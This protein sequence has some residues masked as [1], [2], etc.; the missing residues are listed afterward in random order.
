M[1]KP[2]IFMIMPFEDGFFEVYEMI[3]SKFNDKFEF[4]NA[5]VEDYQQN[6]LADIIQPL[7]DADLVLADLTGFN[8]NVMYELGVA[9]TFGKKTII[10][11]QDELSGLPFD[12][13]TY[14]TK[15]YTTHFKMFN[16]LLEYLDKN[17][18]GAVDNTVAFSNP[19]KDFITADGLDG[20]T[21]I[22][23]ETKDLRIEENGFLDNIAEIETDS[24][25]MVENIQ[26]MSINM[27]QM[28][29]GIQESTNELQRANK[30][31]GQGTVAFVRKQAKKVADIMDKFSNQLREHNNTNEALWSKIEKNSLELVTN[32]KFITNQNDQVIKFLDGLKKLRSAVATSKESVSN[33]REAN[34][35]NKGISRSLNQSINLLDQDLGLYITIMEQI[36]AGIDRV[37][38][39]GNFT[40]SNI[41]QNNYELN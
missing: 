3:K 39:T 13:K 1:V 15:N 25:K 19:V 24:C 35:G 29:S 32:Q 36:Y 7:Y 6:I 30:T 41:S 11:T 34:L 12:L 16:E 27:Q 8:P 23:E 22:N 38:A 37:I 2:K 9:H 20:R 10:I 4:S 17:F 18:R 40:V 21:W 14:R 26:R 33:M 31:G 28:V 5:A